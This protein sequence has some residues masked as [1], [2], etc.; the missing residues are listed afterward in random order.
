MGEVPLYGGP[1]LSGRHPNP[2]GFHMFP[3]LQL[4]WLRGFTFRI[5]GALSLQAD[6][7]SA[8]PYQPPVA[9]CLRQHYHAAVC[10]PP[11]SHRLTL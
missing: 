11:C 10:E 8:E 4:E 3:I 7:Y 2:F 5:I 1:S 6:V 9:L